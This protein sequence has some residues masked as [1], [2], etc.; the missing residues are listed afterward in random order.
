VE[1]LG[2]VGVGIGRCHASLFEEGVEI[3]QADTHPFKRPTRQ[4]VDKL[5][6]SS[7]DRPSVHGV[8]GRVKRAT[9][10]A[11]INHVFFVT[12]YVSSCHVRE[13]T[14]RGV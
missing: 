4:P 5:A 11:V 1:H 2:T 3:R 14:V 7:S 8:M 12:A 13:T 10:R 9:G 6:R